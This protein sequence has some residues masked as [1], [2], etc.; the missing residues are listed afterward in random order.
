MKSGSPAILILIC[1][2]NCIYAAAQSD[3]ADIISYRSALANTQSVYFK[4]LGDQ[5]KLYNGSQ[6]ASYGFVFKTGSPYYKS[7]QFTYGSV[8]YDGILFNN[9]P[10]LYED[11]RELLITKK[12]GYLLQLITA[13][14]SAFTISGHQFIRLV[15][16]SSNRGI[17]KTGFYEVLYP[18]RSL[19]LKKTYKNIQDVA[20]V[21]EGL[22]HFIEESDSYFIKKGNSFIR[23]KSKN[24]M[25]DIF[26]DHQKEIQLFIKKNKLNFRKD[27]ENTLTQVAAYYDQIAG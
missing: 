1:S 2:F 15:A 13:R 14:V 10:L 11:L 25:F 8:L 21:S 4:Q 24:E 19:V 6:Y 16:D 23:V 9:L 18:G 26:P 22:S 7:D 17:S 20:S 12:E 27:E 5:S 3:S